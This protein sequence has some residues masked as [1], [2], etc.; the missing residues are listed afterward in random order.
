M[1]AQ[2][3]FVSKDTH[4]HTQTMSF[5]SKTPQQQR[6]FIKPHE[7]HSGKPKCSECGCDLNADEIGGSRCD[8]CV[9]DDMYSDEPDYDDS[10]DPPTELKFDLK[11]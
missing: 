9:L 8:A 3:C 4:T 5:E 10:N 6:T 11:Q 7:V 1:Q 2:V